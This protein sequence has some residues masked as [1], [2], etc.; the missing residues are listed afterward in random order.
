MKKKIILILVATLV[1]IQFIRPELN[2][3][4]SEETLDFLTITKP[5]DEIAGLIKTSCYDCHSNYTEPQWYMNIAPISW[6][7]ADHVE[8]GQEE[9]NFSEW[10][11]YKLKR[12][13]HKLDEC[14][15]LIE[16]N[17][18]PLNLY[19][20]M[21]SDAKLTSEQKTLLIDWFQQNI[22]E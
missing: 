11:N 16:E 15:E 18:M 14:I 22:Q 13:N 7:I 19:T 17:E 8:E 2:E 5:T 10:G 3:N 1:V 20:L 9:L 6:W 21:H 4:K 12:Q